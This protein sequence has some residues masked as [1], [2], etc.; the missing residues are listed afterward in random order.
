MLC[1]DT[2]NLTRADQP[3]ELM[4]SV[5]FWH[6]L[7]TLGVPTQLVIFENEG[8]AVSR[9]DHLRDMQRRIVGWFDQYLGAP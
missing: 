4:R 3:G 1:Y 6:A 9:V 2:A 7:K 8:H 5:E